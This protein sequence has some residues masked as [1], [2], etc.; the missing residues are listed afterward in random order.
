MAPLGMKAPLTD[1]SFEAD[2]ESTKSVTSDKIDDIYCS[3]LSLACQLCGA[4]IAGIS[5]VTPS[6]QIVLA[7]VG[8]DS[9]SAEPQSGFASHTIDLAMESGDTSIVDYLPDTTRDPDLAN[10]P[11]VLGPPHIRSYAGICVRTSG[12]EH[13]VLFVADPQCRQIQPHS[14]ELLF[15]LGRHFDLMMTTRA[16]VSELT[17]SVTAAGQRVDKLKAEIDRMNSFVSGLN[18]KNERI[19]KINEGL[20]TLAN[21]DGMTGLHN[22]RSFRTR[23]E[24]EFQRS[25][26]YSMPL[27]LMLIDVD[28]FKQFNDTFGHL[29]GDEVLKAVSDILPKNARKIDFVARY[30]GE[31]FAVILGHTAIDAAMEVAERIRAAVEAYPWPQRSVTV[32]IGLTTLHDSMVDINEM[33]ET[34][35]KALYASKHAGRN[36]VTHALSNRTD[37]NDLAAANI[38]QPH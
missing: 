25:M 16:R 14:M 28:H 12:D 20:E 37:S 24:L 33:I 10:N 17:S 1:G 15:E 4:S 11:W 22:H 35:D 19:S 2:A 36:R 18:V 3:V 21:L 38:D 26:R 29:A 34:S 32:S 31:E 8:C 23:L 5:V 7:G 9:S 13:T 30:G 27:S 6:T